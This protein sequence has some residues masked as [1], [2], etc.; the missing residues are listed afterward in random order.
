TFSGQSDTFA[1]LGLGGHGVDLFFCLS[2]WLLGKQLCDEFKKTGT[3]EV[4]RFWLRRWMRTLPAYFAV[5]LAT[6]AQA[7]I[8][9]KLSFC[10]QFFVFLQTY[11]GTMPFF[12]VSWSL[13]VEEYFY[14]FVAPLLFVFC[15]HRN[16][17]ALLPV[18]LLIP[19]AARLS[20]GWVDAHLGWHW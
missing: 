14:L 12:G 5:L 3:I 9:G 2:G 17:R 11:V 15:R 8:H 16:L 19:F 4:R 20:A 10:L 13:C 18:L 7:I 1:F 6:M